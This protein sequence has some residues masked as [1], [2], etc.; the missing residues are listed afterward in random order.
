MYKRKRITKTDK[1]SNAPILG[2]LSNVIC[3][4]KGWDLFSTRD[5]FARELNLVNFNSPCRTHRRPPWTLHWAAHPDCWSS[6]P[7]ITW[8]GP[9]SS[10]TPPARY[11]TWAA[12]SW[13][14]F[15]LQEG[16][17]GQRW[18]IYSPP[19]LATPDWTSLPLPP[20]GDLSAARPALVTALSQ[21]YVTCGK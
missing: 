13:Q 14:D 11:T 10:L 20:P 15:V 6:L 8:T 2:K 4:E 17:A 19:L 9:P 5:S 18:W 12:A 21:D 16:S 7:L 3:G 1:I